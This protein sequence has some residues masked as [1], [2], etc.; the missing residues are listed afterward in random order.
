MEEN[1]LDD[2]TLYGYGDDW[3]RIFEIIPERL[4]EENM[5]HADARDAPEERE[6]WIR[7]AQRNLDFYEMTEINTFREATVRHHSRAVCK[8]LFVS[9]KV[10]FDTGKVLVVFFDDCGRTVRQSRVQPEHCEEIAGAW[11]DGF[12]Y[13]MEGFIEADIGPDHVPGGPCGPPY[14]CR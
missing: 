7:E 8:Y 3:R 14:V 11:F 2:A 5:D 10:A 1:I 4:F 9:E 12:I 13:E 6:A